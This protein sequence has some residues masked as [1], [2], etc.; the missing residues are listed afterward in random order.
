MSVTGP[1]VAL[2]SVRTGGAVHGAGEVTSLDGL[3][4][5]LDD[6]DGSKGTVPSDAYF[7]RFDSWRLCSGQYEEAKSDFPVW[8]HCQ[9]P[10]ALECLQ[11]WGQAEQ[12]RSA[13]LPPP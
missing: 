4:G 9:R 7:E 3:P 5:V 11:L 6:F 10:T 12:R 2:G 13:D 8:H 1:G